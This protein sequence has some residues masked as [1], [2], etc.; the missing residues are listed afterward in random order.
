MRR[1]VST[2]ARVGLEVDW[3]SAVCRETEAEHDLLQIGAVV[4]AMPTRETQTALRFAGHAAAG[5]DA[6]GVVVDLRQIEL[7]GLHHTKHQIG[8]HGG[9]VCSIQFVQCPTVAIIVEQRLGQVARPPKQ[10]AIKLRGPLCEFVEWPATAGDVEDQQQQAL[11]S[12][13]LFIARPR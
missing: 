10:P 2:V 1:I 4:L 11:C 8:H 9:S 12:C 13:H 7:R 3:H 5:L 6:G